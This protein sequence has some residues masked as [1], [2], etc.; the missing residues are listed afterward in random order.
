MNESF[1]HYVWQFQYFHK[2]DLQSC[3]GE[4]ISIL[5]QGVHNT[6]SG[7][8]FSQ[9]KIKIE[10]IEWAG[11]VEIH[12]KS[13]EWYNHK[14][15]KDE[16]YENVILHVVWE[17]DK[18][19]Y[20]KDKTLMP[21]LE[22]KNRV[23]NTLLDSYKKLVNNPASIACEKKFSSVSSIVHYAMLDKALMQRLEFK[24]A[25]VTELLQTNRGDWEETTYQWLLKAFGF[26]VNSDPFSEL[27]KAV[28]FKII[29][30]HT[31]LLEVEAL[32]FGT[33]G[34]LVAKTKDEYITALFDEYKF[35]KKKF[36]LENEELS[37][38]QWKFL[39]LRPSNFP[40][41]RIAQ[42][43][44]IL[45]QHKNIFSKL[46]ETENVK[47]LA[48]IFTASHS[49]YWQKHYRFGKPAKKTVP[50]LGESSIENLMINTVAPLLVAY[51]KAKDEQ[52]Y[53][54]RA[55]DLLLQIPAEQNAITKGWEELGLKIKTA[56]DSQ[57]SI[58]LYNNFCKKRQCLNCSVGIAILKPE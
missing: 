52:S 46:T 58:E 56:F 44:S 51:G 27:A 19:V 53:I 54:D 14:H 1:L 2:G 36:K 40:T 31:Q 42:V 55:V 43:A 47:D 12:V 22:L 29:Q 5:K 48:K 34:M 6:D 24:A 16:A 23:E 26:K 32:L 10:N 57:A 39:R 28:P 21:T 20:R 8:D 11:H 50:P 7:P 3:E 9:A 49:A 37:H 15:E 13:S 18:P 35:L 33:A 45:H 25:A 30:K 41:L 4:K 38:A 17:N